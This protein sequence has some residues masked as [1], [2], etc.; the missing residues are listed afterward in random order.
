MRGTT[1]VEAL[2]CFF[3]AEGRTRGIVRQGCFGSLGPAEVLRKYSGTHGGPESP[4]PLEL[5]TFSIDVNF[6]L[7]VIQIINY[8]VGRPL[9]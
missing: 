6:L 9:E 4:N 1:T 5:S 7:V 3:L 2:R 8:Y